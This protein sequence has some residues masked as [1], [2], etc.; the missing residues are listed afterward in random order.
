MP[1]NVTGLKYVKTTK[2]ASPRERRRRLK[3]NGWH[4]KNGVER[5]R[6]DKL[7]RGRIAQLLS[8]ARSHHDAQLVRAYVDHLRESAHAQ[9]R[10]AF[11]Q[12]AEWAVSI[13][14]GATVG[15]AELGYMCHE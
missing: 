10:A 12:W 5:D 4:G 11:E 13:A 2:S 1:K 3:P 6:A 7:E 9:D 15:P 14:D 8:A